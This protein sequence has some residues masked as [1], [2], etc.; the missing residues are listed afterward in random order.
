MTFN[1]HSSGGH[2]C[3]IFAVDYF[4]KWAEAMPTFNNTGETT[5]LFFFNNVISWFG[6][7]H[8]IVIDH[9]KNFRNHMMTEFTTKL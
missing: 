1:P 9:G 3:I 6:V 5:T 4:T 8:V 7:P 2:G